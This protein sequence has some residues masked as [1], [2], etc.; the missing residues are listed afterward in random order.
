ME[1]FSY[2]IRKLVSLYCKRSLCHLAVGRSENLGGGGSKLMGIVW[3]KK[4]RLICQKLGS[5]VPPSS[6]R[7]PCIICSMFWNSSGNHLGPGISH[8]VPPRDMVSRLVQS[9]FLPTLCLPDF[10]FF[11]FHWISRFIIS[12]VSLIFRFWFVH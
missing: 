2:V 6:F 9:T 4:G 12:N 1:K 8:V 7:H 3:L 5:H 11:F 10:T